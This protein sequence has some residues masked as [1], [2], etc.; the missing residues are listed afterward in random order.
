MC[1]MFSNKIR[2]NNDFSY[3]VVAMPRFMPPAAWAFFC[4]VLCVLNWAVA[5]SNIYKF[6]FLLHKPKSF[7][8]GRMLSEVI[9][10]SPVFVVVK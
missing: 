2:F 9:D 5:V 6:Y 8:L 7:G 4:L 1:Y 10:L 3:Q